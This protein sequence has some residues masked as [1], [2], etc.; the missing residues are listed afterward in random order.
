MADKRERVYTYVSGKAVKGL[1]RLA[2]HRELY[3]KE[4]P[5]A[6][7]YTVITKDRAPSPSRKNGSPNVA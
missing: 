1:Q 5:S 7:G 3:V 2:P 4:S 6:R